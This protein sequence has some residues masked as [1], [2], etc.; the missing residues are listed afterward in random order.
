MIDTDL[1]NKLYPNKYRA[2]KIAT[3]V[4]Q[5]P[6]PVMPVVTQSDAE[7]G[8]LDRYFIKAAN[9]SELIVEV[10]KDQY[11]LFKNNPRFIVA[12]IRWKIRGD[13]NTT[14]TAYGVKV[15][16]VEDYNKNLVSRQ[17]LTFKGLSRYINNYTAYWINI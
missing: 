13:V 9:Q 1:L 14:T 16:G 5:E 8:F 7:N 10:D 4:Q 12:K 6:T 17:D 3:I 2:R 11:N 15:L